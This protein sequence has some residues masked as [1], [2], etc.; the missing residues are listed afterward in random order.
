MLREYKNDGRWRLISLPAVIF[1]LKNRNRVV[2]GTYAFQ[3]DEGGSGRCLSW[4]IR[5][6]S[7][8]QS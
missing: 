1:L 4:N 8:Q 2:L 5:T 7:S 3:R 6:E